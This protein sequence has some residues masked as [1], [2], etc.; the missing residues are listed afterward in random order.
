MLTARRQLDSQPPYTPAR[1]RS[2]PFLVSH[3][4]GARLG[5]RR[6]RLLPVVVRHHDPIGRRQAHTRRCPLPTYSYNTPFRGLCQGA[7]A[8]FV[9]R[10]G[11]MVTHPCRCCGASAQHRPSG[12]GERGACR[13]LR[14]QRFYFFHINSNV[15]DFSIIMSHD[16]GRRL[17]GH[18]RSL[19]PPSVPILTIFVLQQPGA[20]AV[21]PLAINEIALSAAGFDE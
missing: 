7:V 9:P 16:W 3:P 20:Q 6:F 21:V 17:P 5:G 13:G 10:R 19:E 4:V 15:K 11:N 1:H 14:H 18:D 12:F 2:P 8:V